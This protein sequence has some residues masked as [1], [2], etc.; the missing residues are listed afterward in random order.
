MEIF[1]REIFFFFPGKA[2]TQFIRVASLRTGAA[3]IEGG[4]RTQL[5]QN[6]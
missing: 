2:G 5:K 3:K 1:S 4:E 6:S